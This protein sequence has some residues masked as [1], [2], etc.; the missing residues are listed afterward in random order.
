M[1]FARVL[2]MILTPTIDESIQCIS[3]QT[4]RRTLSFVRRGRGLPAV[5][6]FICPM[7]PTAR[8][9]VGEVCQT[10]AY[11]SDCVYSPPIAILR[12]CTHTQM[13]TFI[14]FRSIAVF[15]SC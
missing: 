5:L 4:C 2:A 15:G 14:A 12:E 7:D 9:R 6:S 3:T 8:R 1:G 10:R 13:R 11:R